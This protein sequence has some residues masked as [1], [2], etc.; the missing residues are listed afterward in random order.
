MC[1]RS[2]PRGSLFGYCQIGA[3]HFQAITSIIQAAANVRPHSLF[4]WKRFAI[5][6]SA[7]AVNNSKAISD[8]EHGRRDC[9]HFV[10]KFQRNQSEYPFKKVPEQFQERPDLPFVFL[11]ATTIGEAYEEGFLHSRSV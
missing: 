4:C 1:S 2:S 8:R 5:A 7:N 6:G 3:R 11:C 10:Q 9:V